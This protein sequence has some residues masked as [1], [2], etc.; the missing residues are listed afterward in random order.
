MAS[1]PFPPA[2]ERDKVWLRKSWEEVWKGWSS[3][4]GVL[5]GGA[6]GAKVSVEMDGEVYCESMP[7]LH[8]CVSTGVCVR[9]HPWQPVEEN[10]N[11]PALGIERL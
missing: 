6:A 3:L 8:T 9:R 2:E 11:N 10:L 1:P 7:V 4:G 5:G